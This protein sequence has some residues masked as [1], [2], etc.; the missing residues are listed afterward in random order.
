M[1]PPYIALIPRVIA[2]KL[3]LDMVPSSS[4]DVIYSLVAW[5]FSWNR[6][7]GIVEF[8]DKT[9][10]RNLLY[11]FCHFISGDYVRY[12]H[13]ARVTLAE[14]LGTM[15]KNDLRGIT[16][17]IRFIWSIHS[18]HILLLLFFSRIPKLRAIQLTCLTRSFFF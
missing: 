9:Y 1:N 5:M 4:A 16:L 17:G 12:P 2:L 15:S 11:N 13:N 18:L 6:R 10:R 8:V 14:E 3:F 7:G